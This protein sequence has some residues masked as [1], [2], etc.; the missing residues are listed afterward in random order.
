MLILEMFDLSGK[1]V[2]SQ[3]LNIEEGFNKLR[4]EVADLPVGQYVVKVIG[5]GLDLAAMQV[6]VNR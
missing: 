2:R 4:V 1:M 3:S 6:L 5:E